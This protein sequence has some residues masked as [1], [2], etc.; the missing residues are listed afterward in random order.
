[1][2]MSQKSS[3]EEKFSWEKQCDSLETVLRLSHWEKMWD[4]VHG[5]NVLHIKK[6]VLGGY[7]AFGL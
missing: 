4:I 3:Y 7:S 2:D 6:S 1:M 5:A